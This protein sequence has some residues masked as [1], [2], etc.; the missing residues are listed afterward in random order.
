MHLQCLAQNSE[1]GVTLLNAMAKRLCEDIKS[2]WE[3]GF[4][5]GPYKF[6]RT[7]RRHPHPDDIQFVCSAIKH[8]IANQTPARDQPSSWTTYDDTELHVESQS[9]QVD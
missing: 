4:D 2:W 7:Q 8:V 9:M 1:A 3:R 6:S 5:E